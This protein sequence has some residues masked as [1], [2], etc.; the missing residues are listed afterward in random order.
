[1]SD[2]KPTAEQIKVEPPGLRKD[3]WVAEFVMGECTHENAYGNMYHHDYFCPDCN[4]IIKY[5]KREPKK[6]TT[7]I[8]A[9]WE[10]L[11]KFPEWN[12]VRLVDY[13]NTG[14]EYVEVE[15]TTGK[16]FGASSASVEVK[17]DSNIEE[18]VASTICTAALL[19]VMG[20]AE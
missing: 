10:I 4:H 7:D 12:I 20:D 15:I 13:H 1:M 19:A 5:W 3:A 18:L 9:A 14:E 8:S 6:Y 16:P 11:M 2:D 17:P